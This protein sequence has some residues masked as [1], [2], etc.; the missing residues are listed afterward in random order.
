MK[1]SYVFNTLICCGCTALIFLL[2]FIVY[3]GVLLKSPGYAG[4]FCAVWIAHA[5]G[6]SGTLEPETRPQSAVRVRLLQLLYCILFGSVLFA[7]IEDP[8]NV[9]CWFCMVYGVVYVIFFLRKGDNGA[10]PWTATFM[11]LWMLLTL[12]AFL[13]IVHPITVS[14]AE[15]MVERAGYTDLYRFKVEFNGTFWDTLPD[16]TG[17]GCTMP[18]EKEPLGWYGFRAFKD[19]ERYC[20]V[21][22]AARGQ[23]EV[24][25]NKENNM[26]YKTITRPDGSEQQLAVY[27]GKCRFWMEGIYDSLPE[28]AEKRAEECSLPVKIDRRADGT[29][30]V[31]TQSLVPWETDYGKLEMMA[32]VYLNYLAQV[33]NLPDDDYVKTKLEFGSESSTHDELMT[34]EEREIVK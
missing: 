3:G 24:Q 17:I 26:E 16:G 8:Y 11:M 32:D 29:V 18:E 4:L 14:Q 22:S 9:L 19:G 33:F 10:E 21:V 34:A 2:H 15:N 7:T 20:V 12:G 30:S 6:Y 13:L 25:E 23:I 28:T 5:A 31:G 1:K 27:D